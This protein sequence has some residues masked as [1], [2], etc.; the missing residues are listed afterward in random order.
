MLPRAGT[1]YAPCFFFSRMASSLHL[2]N[3]G[4]ICGS[5]NQQ[6]LCK[7]GLRD[8]KEV[9]GKLIEKQAA[10]IEPDKLSMEAGA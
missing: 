1:V 9:Y 4:V 6:I 5:E 3:G 8:V 10:S 2:E 7:S